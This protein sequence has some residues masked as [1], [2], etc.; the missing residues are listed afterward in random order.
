[1]A[2]QSVGD[3]PYDER[4]AAL[5]PREREVLARSARALERRIA[6]VLVIE[7][8]TVKTHV[9]RI[10]MKPHLRDRVQ[11]VIFAYESGLTRVGSSGSGMI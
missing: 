5:T 3:R 6:E 9:K 10:H 8:S 11:A 2:Q 7:E 4:P 1:M